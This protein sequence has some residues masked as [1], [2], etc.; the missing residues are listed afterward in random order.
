ME[1]PIKAFQHAEQIA[2]LAASLL[3]LF[4]EAGPEID[5]IEADF[6]KA[7]DAIQDLIKQG[8]AIVAEA[9]AKKAPHA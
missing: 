2:S 3:A 5:A 1:N 6:V 8:E 7:K 9:K 4:N